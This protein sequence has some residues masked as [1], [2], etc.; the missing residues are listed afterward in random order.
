[1]SSIKTKAKSP[2]EVHEICLNNCKVKDCAKC[3]FVSWV[4]LEEAITAIFDKNME[5]FAEIKILEDKIEAFRKYIYIEPDYKHP[6]KEFLL[7]MNSINS[8]FEEVFGEVA[9]N[10][11]RFTSGNGKE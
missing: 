4:P 2:A 3:S 7:L 5:R 11:N 1:M 6:D 9:T 10:A 8:K